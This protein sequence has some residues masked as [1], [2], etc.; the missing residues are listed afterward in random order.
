MILDWYP[1]WYPYLFPSVDLMTFCF[2]LFGYVNAK[3]GNFPDFELGVGLYIPSFCGCV[4]MVGFVGYALGGFFGLS[5]PC[6]FYGSARL[7]CT[8]GNE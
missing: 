8:Y 4:L 2:G 5:R 6:E 1:F 7:I 3:N